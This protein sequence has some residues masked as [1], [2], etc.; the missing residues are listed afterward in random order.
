VLDIITKTPAGVTAVLSRG[1][2]AVAVEV[3]SR[4]RE[5]AKERVTRRFPGEVTAEGR[6]AAGRQLREYFAGKRRAFDIECELEGL[7][8]FQRKA[9]LTA[10]AKAPFGRTMTYGELAKAAG[11]PRA[12]R[13][14]GQAMASNPVGIIIPCHRI[15]G[16][17]GLGGYSGA[18]GTATKKALLAF[19]GAAAERTARPLSGGPRRKTPRPA[20]PR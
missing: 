6:S 15:V 3:G 12:A 10:A 17:D 19:E 2:K 16:A 1:G 8:P 9:L 11:S 20:K 7:G 18:G 13:A 5:E 14:V 4:T